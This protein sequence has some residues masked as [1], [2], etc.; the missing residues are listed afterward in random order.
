MSPKEMYN[1]RV[2]GVKNQPET[3]VAMKDQ[4]KIKEQVKAT[5]SAS[6]PGTSEPRAPS[7]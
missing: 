2:G 3:R 7:P 4:D 5:F 6:P 1:T